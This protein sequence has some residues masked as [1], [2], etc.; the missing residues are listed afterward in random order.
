MYYCTSPTVPVGVTAVPLNVAV[1]L[2]CVETP[3]AT[4]IADLVGKLPT[5]VIEYAVAEI[6]HNVVPL[7]EAL[8]YVNEPVV[9]KVPTP[10]IWYIEEVDSATSVLLLIVTLPEGLILFA[11]KECVWLKSSTHVL[12]VTGKRLSPALF[13]ICIFLLAIKPYLLKYSDFQFKLLS[14]VIYFQLVFAHII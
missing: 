6:T 2:G 3:V 14:Q 7:T 12:L 13:L 4:V 11:V 10:V 5:F 9:G 8:L 1:K